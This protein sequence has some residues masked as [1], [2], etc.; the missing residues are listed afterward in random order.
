M[1]GL[2][3]RAAAA[4]AR[5]ARARS[6]GP[7][8]APRGVELRLL[9]GADHYEELVAREIPSA[10]VS[11]WIAT[12]NLKELR[13]EAAIGTRARARGRYV[14]ILERFADLAAQGVELRILHG[15]TPS[16]AFQSELAA[17]PA[18]AAR[19]ELRECPRVHMKIVAIDGRLL[20]LGSANFTGAGLGARSEGK[21]N[22]ELGVLTGDD[23]LLDVAQARFDAVWS[24]RECG[25]CR[26]RA[27][28]PAPIDTLTASAPRSATAPAA[29]SSAKRP[30]K[31]P[32]PRRRP[33][34]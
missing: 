11:L 26:L 21:R 13:V 28:C 19:L 4:S 20:Y 6:R 24:G 1:K 22:F 16:R 2:V 31:R 10:K 9:S 23:Y 8:P 17:R 3:A 18:L 12:A 5:A 7:R 29:P 14:S 15:R 30:R 32:G 25:A 34:R 27:E 33:A